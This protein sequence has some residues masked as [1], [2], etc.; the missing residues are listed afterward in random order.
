MLGRGLYNEFGIDKPVGYDDCAVGDKFPKIG[1][2]LLTR[3]TADAYNFFKP[4]VI[5]PFSVTMK[6]GPDHISYTCNAS[7]YRGYAFRLLKTIALA[8]TMFSITYRFENSGS[9]PIITNE[10]VHNFLAINRKQIDHQYKLRF[11]FEIE[12]SQFGETVNPDTV[13][14]FG[15]DTLTWQSQP[16]KQFFFSNLHSGHTDNIFWMLEHSGEK[17]GIKESAGFPILRM[18]L[19]GAGH[20]VS[21]ELFYELKAEPG[22]TKTWVRTYEVYYL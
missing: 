7:E 12:P 16:K 6:K 1:I 9:Q 8:D 4:Y 2:G 20:V 21:P 14:R 5:D 3:D 18:N 22:E 17:V 11:P 13:V 10:Y 15:K 19:W